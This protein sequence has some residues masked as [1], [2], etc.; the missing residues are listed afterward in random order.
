VRHK[1]MN[2]RFKDVWLPGA[3]FYLT[4]AAALVLTGAVLL[5][6]W[7]A[8]ESA[9]PLV[10]LY[11]DDVTVRRTSLFSA[12]G[13]VVTAF[14]FFRPKRAPKPPDVTHVAGA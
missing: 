11:A 6:P 9:H 13:L 8:G 3:C 1:I 12:L 14:V 4:L 7:F 2:D 10:G 5:A